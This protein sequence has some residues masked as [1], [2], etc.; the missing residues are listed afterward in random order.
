MNGETPPL[1]YAPP[2]GP[3]IPPRP[4]VASAA[5]APG[6]EHG[7]SRPLTAY[8]WPVGAAIAFVVMTFALDLLG[9]YGVRVAL[10][11][12]RGSVA[13]ALAVGAILLVVYA[14]QLG[15]VWIV[16]HRRGHRLAESVGIRRVPRLRAWVG[17]AI[18]LAVFVRV[19]ALVYSEVVIS[20]GLK[21][22]GQNAD[23]LRYFAPGPVGSLMLVIIVV[24]VAPLVEEIVFR[25]IVLA[26]LR[27]RWGDR[28][29]ILVSSLVFAALHL[30]LFSFL[31]IFAVALVLGALF[32]RSR[33]LWVNIA[34]HS[35]FNGIGVIL[36]LVLRSRGLV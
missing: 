30:N 20:S 25:G 35:A 31:P 26:S 34:C 11:V 28:A 7:D 14:V 6:G 3:P 4:P 16:A 17:S 2:A 32:V 15:V 29:A 5:P 33:S 1:A 10:K 19:L 18:G 9:G 12:V 27:E 8:V 21:L 13:Q 23:P 24:L 22:Q 36:L